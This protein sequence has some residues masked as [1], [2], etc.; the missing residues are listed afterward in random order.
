M[1]V[2]ANDGLPLPLSSEEEEELVNKLKDGDENIRSILYERNLRLIVYIARKFE[3]TGVYVEDLISVGTIGLI[4]ALD[5]LPKSNKIQF[6]TY[7]A[8]CIENE[9]L[10]H[11]RR[12]GTTEEELSFYE[13]VNID[14]D[15]IEKI[16]L[17]EFIGNEVD[18]ETLLRVVN[19]LN[20]RAKEIIILRCGLNG[21]KEKTQK[22]VADLL[23]ISQSYIARLEKKIIKRMQKEINITEQKYNGCGE[24]V[25][26]ELKCK[27][28][29]NVLHSNSKFCDQ[30]GVKIEKKLICNSCCTELD[31]KAKFCHICGTKVNSE[32]EVTS[33]IRCIKCDATLSIND[34]SCSKCGIDISK[35]LEESKMN[36]L[37]TDIQYII[38]DNEVIIIKY[39]GKLSNIN[40]PNY[41]EGYP[42][43]TIG[44]SAFKGN[45]N[46]R[47]VIIPL[48]VRELGDSA[49]ED[50]S[51]LIDVIFISD[52]TSIGNR[53]FYN[54]GGYD[55]Y[56]EVVEDSPAHE[57]IEKMGLRN[58][59]IWP[60]F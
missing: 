30:C 45:D 26:G 5:T 49:F 40:I 4:K 35:F 60:K 44:E 9:I 54:A 48:S 33:K 11:L 8:R 36:D 47:K 25:M 12:N 13:P 1:A 39:T 15:N 7:A 23:G 43:R 52:K 32:L 10:I 34:T 2:T 28:C 20:D 16:N 59:Q 17:N 19:G 41:I 22:E 50:C 42:V 18:D 14:W 38:E 31:N 57:F 56:F 51:N 53:T 29:G 37:L 3:N 27:S 58:R 55:M 6:K 24:E 21:T 46:V